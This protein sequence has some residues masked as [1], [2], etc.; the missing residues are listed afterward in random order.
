MVGKRSQLAALALLGFVY[1]SACDEEKPRD[2]PSCGESYFSFE[3]S[4]PGEAVS[5][6]CVPVEFAALGYLAVPQRGSGPRVCSLATT[7]LQS[8]T[9]TPAGGRA[10]LTVIGNQTWMD[11]ARTSGHNGSFSFRFVPT[12]QDAAIQGIPSYNAVFP[13]EQCPA[14]IVRGN[15]RRIGEPIELRMDT[16]CRLDM[17]MTPADP[18]APTLHALHIRARIDQ[19]GVRDADT[20][21]PFTEYTCPVD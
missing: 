12:G 3:Y 14:S 11:V 5:S 2:L 6:V 1:L 8:T 9:A 17:A 16:P 19:I 15:A 18:N 13:T 10:S 21:Q 20:S 4:F 7:H